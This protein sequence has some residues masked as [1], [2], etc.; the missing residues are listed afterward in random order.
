MRTAFRQLEARFE[1]L[2]RINDNHQYV[3]DQLKDENRVQ[4]L[5]NKHLQTSIDELYVW[6]KEHHHA[7]TSQPEE[8]GKYL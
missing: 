6:K 4:Q 5:V 8:R 2:E 3:I 1:E 7:V